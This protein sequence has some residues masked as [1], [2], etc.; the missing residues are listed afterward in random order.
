MISKLSPTVNFMQLHETSSKE[1]WGIDLIEDGKSISRLWIANRQMRIG[2][3][4][5]KVGGIA[6]VGTD[7][8]YRNK[9]LARQVL[10]ASLSLMQREGYDVSFL[11]GIQGFY[12]KFDFAT[13]MPE[14]DL[15]L[16]TRAAERATKVLKMR[17]IKKGEMPQ[18]ARIYNRDHAKLTASCVRDV[19]NWHGFPMGSGFFVPCFVRV[20]IDARD[21]VVGYAVYDEVKDRCRIAEVGGQGADV[22]GT[23]LHD[24]ARRAVALRREKLSLSLPPEHAFALFC[25]DYGC[26][27]RTTYERNAGPMGRIINL[28]PFIEKLLPE[29][30]QRW[31]SSEHSTLS[32]RTDIGHFSLRWRGQ[33][34]TIGDATTR[35][36]V[37]INQDAL[38]QLCL[39]YKT[40]SDLK[41]DQKLRASAAQLAQLEQLFP[42]QQAHMFWPDR[43]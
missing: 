21:R 19:R 42:L 4:V 1:G 22:F 26:S 13:C 8:N 31:V 9:G 27:A 25:R 40:A 5:V 11:Y 36:A 24:M 16:D 7:R 30:E 18:V 29:L 38:M 39:G 37:R 41:S 35:G 2:A 43:F 3:A 10:D 33:H 23:L 14:H 28:R 15:E 6:G 34:L 20:V 17:A 32:I 12:D